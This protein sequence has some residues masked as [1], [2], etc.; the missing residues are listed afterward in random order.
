MTFYSV[1]INK[2]E[3]QKDLKPIQKKLNEYGFRGYVFNVGDGYALRVAAYPN[4]EQAETMRK[5]L[6]QR[7]FVAFIR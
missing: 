1:Y 3:N 5:Y 4:Q 7:G 2:C 6:A